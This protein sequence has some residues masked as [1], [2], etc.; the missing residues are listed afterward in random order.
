MP[1][2]ENTQQ[3]TDWIMFG[4]TL[5]TILLLCMPIYI[6]KEAASE[7]IVVAYDFVTQ[8]FGFLYIWYAVAVM[9]FL[10]WL[11]SSKYG[12]IKLGGPQDTVEFSTISWVGMLFS[13]GV[14]A[15]LLYWSVVEW[16]YYIE[17]PPFGIEGGS[18]SA[19]EWASAY[20]LFHWGPSAW[21][22]YCLPT[23]AIAYAFYVRKIPYL[24]LSTGLASFLPKGI[25]SARGRFVDFL[26]MINLIGGTGTSLGLV[27]PMIAGGA[28][29]MFGLEH[30][31]LLEV[32]IVIISIIIFGT[33]AYMGLKKGIKILS[34]FNV[35]LAFV[36]LFFVLAVG[37]TVFILKTSTN[38]IGLMLQ[39]FIRMSL[40]TDPIA[41]SGFVENW[42]IFY[43]AW[44]VAY[45]PFVGI[46]VAR[47]SKG[48]SIRQVITGMLIYGSLGAWMFFMI[49]GNYALHLEI[50]D[51]LNI[52]SLLHDGS[53]ATAAAI[54]E[55]ML[56]LPWGIL[57]LIVFVIISLVFSATTYDS[58]SY[59]LASISTKR[60]KAG[61]NPARWNRLFWAFGLA[62]LPVSL[63]FIDGGLKVILSSTIVVSLPLLIVNILMIRSLFLMLR[64]DD[65]KLN[66]K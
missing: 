42:T 20:G 48:R 18:D 16:G 66:S 45:A 34:D 41:S 23:I 62:I 38:S 36:L 47:I 63:L 44:W 52:S 40:W 21:A 65:Q 50:N 35:L 25:N 3:P 32:Y 12:K 64:A 37:P 9:I 58:A 53:K 29:K 13:A 33:S 8:K 30:N 31:F 27:S 19:K 60:L 49:F 17:S 61:E 26:F 28:A 7:L 2:T 54:S 57:V 22:I 4:A 1:K 56:S 59:T 11:A 6:D 10:I 14:G 5:G 39:N 15:G 51:L 55:I 43:W 46:F 24:R